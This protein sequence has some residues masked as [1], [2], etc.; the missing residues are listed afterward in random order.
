MLEAAARLFARHGIEATSVDDVAAAAGFTKGAVYSNF[1]SKQ[2]LVD[3]LI[4][5]RTAA[6]LQSGLEAVAAFLGPGAD[7]PLASRARTLGD[8]LTAAAQDRHDWHL[9][10]MELWQRSARSS[11]SDEETDQLRAQRRSLLAAVEQGV[12]QH[13]DSAGAALPLP[14]RDL[15]VVIMAL[16]NGLALERMLAPEDVPDELMGRVLALLVSE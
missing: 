4:E 13:A 16:A 15:A 3:A 14:A 8:G 5:D 12:A 10:L 11:I 1:G 6:Y 9:L 2:G 7:L